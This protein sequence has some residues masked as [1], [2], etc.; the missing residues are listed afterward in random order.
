MLPMNVFRYIGLLK[1]LSSKK[2]SDL[3]LIRP[4]NEAHNRE[5]IFSES[6]KICTK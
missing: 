2:L 4:E 5:D 1:S 3:K 6:L